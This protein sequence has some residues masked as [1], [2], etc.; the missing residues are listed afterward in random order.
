MN[1]N[2]EKA[3][4]YSLITFLKDHII[5]IP[6]MQRDYAQGRD[7]AEATNIRNLFISTILDAVFDGK[8]LSLDFTYGDSKN[9]D[10]RRYYPID[11][12]QRLTTLF[13]VYAYVL[14]KA[15]REK[16]KETIKNLEFLQNFR[17]EERYKAEEYLKELLSE[18]LNE[19]RLTMPELWHKNPTAEGLARTFSQILIAFEKKKV[20]KKIIVLKAKDYLERLE[21]ITFLEISS[22]LPDDV[23][24]K[25]NARGRTLT[26]F[27]VF[28]AGVVNKFKKEECNGFAEVANKFYEKLFKK[29]GNN[30]DIDIDKCVTEKIMG[31]IRNWFAFLECPIGNKNFISNNLYDYI[32]FDDYFEN[33]NFKNTIKNIEAVDNNYAIRT[34]SSFFFFFL[35][36][37]EEDPEKLIDNTLPDRKKGKFEIKNKMN[38][39][40]AD[41]L[42]ACIAFFGRKRE[43]AEYDNLKDWMRFACNILD[44]TDNS[45]ERTKLFVSI[46]MS[47][48][49]KKEIECY[50]IENA[51][52]L[53]TQLEEE[54][55]KLNL[56]ENNKSWAKPIIEAE[57][58]E[59]L[60]GRISVLLNI[61]GATEEPEKFRSY[62]KC[63]KDL[64][65]SCMSDTVRNG[66]KFAL[67]LLAYYEENLPKAG[68]RIPVKFS[69]PE[70]AKD[71]LY[72]SMAGTFRDYAYDV[73]CRKS[74]KVATDDSPYWIQSLCGEFG[75][76]L[77]E[78]T[79]SDTSGFVST[80]RGSLP[81]L[82]SK[83]GCTWHSYNNVVLSERNEYI[84]KLLTTD[85][86]KLAN[87][88]YNTID[89]V[90]PFFKEWEI[91]LKFEGKYHFRTED[92]I[93][94]K[95]FLL[96]QEDK[97]IISPET[98]THYCVNI[99]D[100]QSVVEE[101]R[102]VIDKAQKEGFS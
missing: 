2:E 84:S 66:T 37:E 62:Y 89:N 14:I 26:D 22:N 36:A 8:D 87:T 18:K 65:D 38:S 97:E 13:L 68:T 50:Q 59:I 75:A 3:K 76:K 70:T 41:I 20:E 9:N 64:W 86:F 21:K 17:F 54:Q 27:E 71:M 51:P 58:L 85:E 16:D 32:A 93:P 102:T 99:K 96:D 52:A 100:S 95:I 74:R 24:C 34:L 31:I 12:Q 1:S 56:I 60:N 72:N 81:V 11:G 6:A 69:D 48:D 47:C 35:H 28:K 78:A 94:E 92:W 40:S 46:G 77:I 91:L 29:Y 53:K 83:Y 57:N 43:W 67:T 61:T 42:P 45:L 10:A 80:Y 15:R 73:V 7:N 39:D 79:C 23:F 88:K 33:A 49:I 82:W 101:A 25:M 98:G 63:L 44:N 30:Q 55:R 19:G 5:V 4:N 90:L